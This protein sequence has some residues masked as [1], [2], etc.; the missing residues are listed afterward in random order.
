MD[1]ERKF[2]EAL[3]AATELGIMPRSLLAAV[4]TAFTPERLSADERRFLEGPF[5]VHQSAWNETRPKW[6]EDIAAGERVAIAL[7][8]APAGMIIGPAELAMVM[9]GA[10]LDAPMRSDCADLYMWATCNAVAKRDNKPV[11]EVFADVGMKP[12]EDE[13]VLG[14]GYSQIA[15][16]YRELAH[17]IRRKVIRAQQERERA[18]RREAKEA[19]TAPKVAPVKIAEAATPKPTRPVVAVQLDMFTEKD[20]AA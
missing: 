3:V 5:V 11:A 17:E 20:E 9:Y 7:G 6:L 18:A 4:T 16:T 8:C 14:G 15:H 2:D 13:Q 19:K 12:I 10:S 1:R